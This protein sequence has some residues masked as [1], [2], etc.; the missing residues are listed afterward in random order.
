MPGAKKGLSCVGPTHVLLTLELSSKN[1]DSERRE[2]VVHMGKKGL[3]EGQRG[4]YQP[5]VLES[6]ASSRAINTFL[7]CLTKEF[8]KI[9]EVQ[10]HT[11]GKIQGP[12]VG[13]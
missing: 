9:E 5:L 3:E 12:G 11:S 7:T 13:A 10:S 6:L 4:W 1:C 8:Q 2:S